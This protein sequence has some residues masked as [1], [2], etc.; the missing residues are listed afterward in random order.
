MLV[1]TGFTMTL[2]AHTMLKGH[3]VWTWSHSPL[4]SRLESLTQL[5]KNKNAC[6]VETVGICAVMKGGLEKS[7]SNHFNLILFKHLFKGAFLIEF[8]TREVVR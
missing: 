4:V 8:W 5:Q 3:G 1:V 2:E 7:V 6:L